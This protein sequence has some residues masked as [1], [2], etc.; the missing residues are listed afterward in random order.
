MRYS[1]LSHSALSIQSSIR[2]HIK[3]LATP[4]QVV[5]QSENTAGIFQKMKRLQD[6]EFS[7]GQIFE[8]NDFLRESDD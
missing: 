3:E 2:R 4:C 6:L 1:F 8:R 7:Y 5:S